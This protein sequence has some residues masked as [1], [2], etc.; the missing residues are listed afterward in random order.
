MEK[1][2]VLFFEVTQ[3]CNAHCDHCGSRCDINSEEGISSELF[4]SVLLDV[5]KNIGTDAMLNITGGEP[6]L[7]KD[8]FDVC[9]Y[10]NQ[11]GFDW[12]MVTNGTLI[13]K[14]N[15]QKMKQC[16]MKTISISIDGM[17]STHESFRHLPKGSFDKILRN[18]QLLQKENF[19]EHIQVTF[20]ANKKNLY[21]LPILW[22]TLNNLHIDSLRVS[23]IDLIGR[24]KENKDLLLDKKDFE[25]L[26]EFMNST[27][28]TN[29]LHCVWSCSHYFGNTDKPDALGR[30][31]ECFTGKRVA[32]I[33][34][35]GDIFVCPN[36]PRKPELIQGNVKK[37]VFSE[38]W[39]NGFQFFR[40]RP[41][42][43]TCNSCEHKTF[44]NGDSLHTWN[45]D[46]NKPSFCYKEWKQNDIES[47]NEF[48]KLA[49]KIGGSPIQLTHGSDSCIN[50]FDIKSEIPPERVVLVKDSAY[51]D[52]KNY[53]H[54]GEMHPVS[55]YEQ[56][57]G[58]VGSKNGNTYQIE[59][60]FPCFLKNRVRNMG[61]IDSEII[62]EAYKETQIINDNLNYLTKENN[63]LKLLGFIH[64]HPLDVNFQY[65]D[66]DIKFH[67]MMFDELGDFLGMIINPQEKR[68]K[69]YEGKNINGIKVTREKSD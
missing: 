38:V 27:N 43:D 60:V 17:A 69:A 35:N 34:Y 59:Y 62:D 10:A 49:E 68:I 56:M 4:K 14:E 33:L 12:G 22:N 51:Q 15:I 63:H 18:I 67:K 21:E 7:Y 2:K 29:Q 24:A 11:L 9:S 20:I 57:M 64:S 54:V 32:S 48:Q 53:F 5:K 26:F 41:L 52:I 45:F 1:L 36:V 46:E 16:G 28:E 65:S 39:K 3:K 55:M 47:E 44:C 31:F 42:N 25:Y 50:I 13:T 8:L 61:Y 19:L 40:N 37:D 6:L 23:C 58:L 66:G 30:H